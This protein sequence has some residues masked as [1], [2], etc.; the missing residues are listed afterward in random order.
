MKDQYKKQYLL[1]RQIIGV[2]GIIF[3]I[4]LLAGCLISSFGA[5]PTSFS[6]SYY[7]PMRD[8]FVGALFVIGFF[9]GAYKGYDKLDMV[10]CITMGVSAVFA[11]LIPTPEIPH[12]IFASI[13]FLGMAYMSFFMF[14]KTDKY[15]ILTKRKLKRNVVYRV[16][17]VIILLCL[18][19]I[20][21]TKFIPDADKYKLVFWLEWLLL[22][23]F[24]V[25]WVVKGEVLL[26]DKI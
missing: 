24:S 25:P 1:L 20:G 14:T 17:G 2:V 15:Y 8:H 9:L 10:I 13:T 26:K 19:M 6:E 21:L 5:I 7:T 16:C 22:W 18:I 4:V 11:A 12:F 23:A 3:P